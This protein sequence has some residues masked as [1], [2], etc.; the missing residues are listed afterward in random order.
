LNIGSTPASR[1]RAA[2]VPAFAA[3]VS[4]SLL[5]ERSPIAPSR[6]LARQGQLL[7]LWALPGQ[8]HALGL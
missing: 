1:S 3:T 4:G 8:G 2:N 7:R 6:E 5:K